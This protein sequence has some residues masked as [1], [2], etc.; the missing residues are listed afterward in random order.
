MRKYMS[1]QPRP[2]S[3]PV[4]P[5]AEQQVPPKDPVTPGDVS[6]HAGSADFP[7]REDQSDRSRLTLEEE[8]LNLDD[9]LKP[10]GRICAAPAIDHYFYFCHRKCNVHVH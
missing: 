8:G 5:A 1:N 3:Q 2:S 10:G 6:G 4:D 9:P 7:E